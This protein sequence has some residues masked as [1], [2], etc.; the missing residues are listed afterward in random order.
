MT[1]DLDAFIAEREALVEPF[2]FTFAGGEWTA[3]TSRPDVRFAMLLDRGDVGGAL[4]LML[5]VD[6]Y[7]RLIATGAP[8]ATEDLVELL[9]RWTAHAGT[10]LGESS[11]SSG[12]SSRTGRRSRPTSKTTT[13]SA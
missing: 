12:S 3:L 2:T 11:A 4:T 1:F 8:F 10:S 13:A 5:G 6:G 7:N 9:K